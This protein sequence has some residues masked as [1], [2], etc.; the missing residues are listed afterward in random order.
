MCVPWADDLLGEGFAVRRNMLTGGDALHA[1]AAGA[2]RER[3]SPLP[4]AAGAGAGGGAAHWWE[5]ARP[6]VCRAL[7]DA[8]RG[9]PYVD[10]R[11][12]DHADPVTPLGQVPA[13]VL[14]M[15]GKAP[16]ER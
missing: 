9:I 4:G 11:V 1:M 10:V 16:A 6:A 2:E 3:A 8:P 12:D 15:L 14:A 7:G 13:E 5:Q